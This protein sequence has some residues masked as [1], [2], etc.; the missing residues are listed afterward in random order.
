MDKLVA[1]SHFL[2][3]AGPTQN[4]TRRFMPLQLHSHSLKPPAGKQF[5]AVHSTCPRSYTRIPEAPASKK[6]G[7][8]DGTPLPEAGFVAGKCIEQLPRQSGNKALFPTYSGAK[9]CVP[10]SSKAIV[11]TAMT[12][13]R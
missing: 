7:A 3:H 6:F 5:G 1:L 13:K 9:T 10:P 8:I 12:A 4:V 2:L 11:F